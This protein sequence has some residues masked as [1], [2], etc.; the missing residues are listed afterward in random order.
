MQLAELI[1]LA[2]KRLNVKELAHLADDA[3]LLSSR[4]PK[5]DGKRFSSQAFV[6]LV[7][8]LDTK[9]TLRAGAFRILLRVLDKF[10]SAG[11]TVWEV[12][13]VGFLIKYASDHGF[14]KDKGFRHELAARVARLIDMA[15]N[16]R[17][18]ELDRWALMNPKTWERLRKSL[19]E[20]DPAPAAPPAAGDA[21]QPARRARRRSS[22]R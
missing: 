18:S 10:L 5:S 12:D 14:R 15:E 8:L 3:A 1:H 19:E 6:A 16:C 2:F 17:E 20:L 22:R 11:P 21:D 4:G 13:Q 9:H 7:G